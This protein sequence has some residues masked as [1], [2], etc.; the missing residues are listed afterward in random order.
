[1]KFPS[2]VIGMMKSQVKTHGEAGQHDYDISHVLHN[3]L[4]SHPPTIVSASGSY[5]TLST[6]ERVLYGCTGTAIASIGYGNREVQ[7]AVMKQ[8]P[9]VYYTHTVPFTI[10]VAEFLVDIS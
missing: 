5:I 7:T 4:A 10:N 9:T 3:T 8:I 1:M 6:G 2:C